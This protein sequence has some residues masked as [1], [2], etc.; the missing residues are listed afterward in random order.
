MLVWGENAFEEVCRHLLSHH[1]DRFTLAL[2]TLLAP[3]RLRVLCKGMGADSKP[4]AS[5][6]RKVCADAVAAD[7]DPDTKALMVGMPVDQCV[8]EHHAHLLYMHEC[9]VP[10]RLKW[11]FCH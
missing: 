2:M 4:T 8:H 11:I 9:I 3:I 10:F 6:L 5:S 7:P 1:V